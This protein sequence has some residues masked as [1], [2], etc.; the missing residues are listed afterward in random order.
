MT[1]RWLSIRHCAHRLLRFSFRLCQ[2]RQRP[3]QLLLILLR[4]KC[5]IWLILML[6]TWKNRLSKSKSV[7]KK[8][9][10]RLVRSLWPRTLWSPSLRAT[11]IRMHQVFVTF[12][13]LTAWFLLRNQ[14]V[15]TLQA[16]ILL[17]DQETMILVTL[18]TLRWHKPT[19]VGTSS[20]LESTTSR[21]TIAVARSSFGICSVIWSSS[22]RTTSPGQCRPTRSSPLTTPPSSTSAT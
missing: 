20:T 14:S 21:A 10:R 16:R 17:T 2:R 11:R 4:Q 6:T 12:L 9:L 19:R 3:L 5:S 18:S 22:L 7:G 8:S 15:E 1:L 13:T